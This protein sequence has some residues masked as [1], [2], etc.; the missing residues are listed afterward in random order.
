MSSIA[1]GCTDWY[2]VTTYYDEYYNIIE[3]TS[4]YLGTTCVGCNDNNYET[5]CPGTGGGGGND[6][7][8]GSTEEWEVEISSSSEEEGGFQGD[9]PSGVSTEPR[10]ELTY[11]AL[12][13]FN[14]TNN[15]PIITSVDVFPITIRFDHREVMYVTSN[16]TL[17]WRSAFITQQTNGY[18]ILTYPS[19]LIW[20]AGLLHKDYVWWG[21]AELDV[22]PISHMKVD[23]RVY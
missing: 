8:N 2:L 12:K 20:W 5:L 17:V 6:G 1:E 13:K 7:N 19:V 16:G 3:Q 22:K 14:K 15:I 4:E 11:S 18:T 10:I 23:S 9:S 21:G